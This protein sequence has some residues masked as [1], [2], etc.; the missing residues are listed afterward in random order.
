M[1]WRYQATKRTIYSSTGE[2]EEYFEVREVYEGIEDSTSLS[3]TAEPVAAISET[4]EGL[5]EVLN[6]MLADVE[7]FDVLDLDAEE[8]EDES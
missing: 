5:I 7:H 6:M 1:T 4:K 2:Q 3:W 8:A